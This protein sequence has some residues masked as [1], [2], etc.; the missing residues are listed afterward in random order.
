[1]DKRVFT[2]K[3]LEEMGRKTLDLVLETIDAGD[4]E[5]AKK[6]SKR[7]YRE[8]QGMHDLY[9][10]WV[11]A[12]MTHIY[13]KHGEEDFH[14]AMRKAVA[15]FLEP[16]KDIYDKVDFK[17]KVELMAGAARGH[18]QAAVLEED[19][20]KVTMKCDICGSGQL[21]FEGGFY[22]PP[23]NFTMI[24]KPA[25]FTYGMKDFPIY[26]CHAPVIEEMQIDWKGEP[27]YASFPPQKMARESC[28]CCI[29]K[30]KKYIPDEVY[31]RVGKK[32]PKTD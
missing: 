23:H 1:M 16:T 19:D 2:K 24:Q 10:E 13:E 5:K 6:L 15:A 26:C 18:G 27:V 21:Q 17:R 20:E 11:T 12:L 32:K 3:E 4:K 7:M 30:D 31:T 22:G 8:W 14:E 28:L 25:V 29:Y 9:R